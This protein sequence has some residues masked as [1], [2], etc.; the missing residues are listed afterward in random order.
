MN[1]SVFNQIQS[2][3]ALLGMISFLMFSI[4]AL[5]ARVGAHIPHVLHEMIDFVHITL[6]LSTVAYLLVVA[7]LASHKT[8]LEQHWQAVY[9]QTRTQPQR[10][11]VEGAFRSERGWLGHS[12]RRSLAPYLQLRCELL[13]RQQYFD[14]LHSRTASLDYVLYLRL[15]SERV[16]GQLVH[17]G[18]SAW[19]ALLASFGFTFLCFDGAAWAAGV[20]PRAGEQAFCAVEAAAFEA[21]CNCTL[22]GGGELA[23]TAPHGVTARHAVH[24][25]GHC[26]WMCEQ[27]EEY[28]AAAVANVGLQTIGIVWIWSVLLLGGSFTWASTSRVF[29]AFSAG[30]VATPSPEMVAPSP[31]A[32]MAMADAGTLNLNTPSESLL[33]SLLTASESLSSSSSSKTAAALSWR[34]GFGFGVCVEGERER[35][36]RSERRTKGEKEAL[37]FWRTR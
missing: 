15:S 2:E 34:F 12:W 31:D 21:R 20:Q 10:I 29:R 28:I 24:C 11:A 17:L 26:T 25:S 23:S 18:P 16:L 1:P 36:K 32:L 35:R 6:F 4:P 27:G 14:L 8:K 30:S 19:L 33:T 5:A 22:C 9:D 7:A 13:L 3:C 37:A